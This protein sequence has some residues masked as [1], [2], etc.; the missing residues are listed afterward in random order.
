MSAERDITEVRGYRF[1]SERVVA[2]TYAEGLLVGKVKK[3][4]RNLPYTVSAQ[5][6]AIL[7]IE[8]ASAQELEAMRKKIEE[9]LSRE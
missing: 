9:K 2:F 3:D 6:V 7:H 5:S 1:T 8:N 4:G